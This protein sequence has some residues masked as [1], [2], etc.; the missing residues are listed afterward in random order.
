V[1]TN[2]WQGALTEMASSS[3]CGALLA[4]TLTVAHPKVVTTDDASLMSETCRR[5]VE[6]LET[7]DLLL[8]NSERRIHLCSLSFTP[9][10]L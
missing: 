8:M 5:A 3:G 1:Q 6:K 10:I 7:A 4:S 2:S 9:H